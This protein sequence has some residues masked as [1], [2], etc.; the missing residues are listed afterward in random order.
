[1]AADSNPTLDRI[2][3]DSSRRTHRDLWPVPVRA[4]VDKVRV[5]AHL[6]AQLAALQND[7]VANVGA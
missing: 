3:T 7:E 6:T 2:V 4:P 1:M 5:L